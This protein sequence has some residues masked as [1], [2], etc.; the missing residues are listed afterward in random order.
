[1]EA[2]V[3]TD[4]DQNHSV[5][6]IMKPGSGISAGSTTPWRITLFEFALSIPVLL[7]IPIVAGGITAAFAC[8]LA[9]IPV[10]NLVL[11]WIIWG[12]ATPLIYTVWLLLCLVISALDVQSRRWYRGLKKVPR[13]SSSEGV[14]KFYP[15]I[16]LY[17]RMRFLYSLPMI[18]SLLW[19]P[20]I[21]WLVLWSYAPSAH[22]GF[23]SAILGKL[24][25]PD[26]TEVGERAIVGSGVS[27][28]AHSLTRNPDGTRLLT[29]APIMIGPRAVIG[30]DS[31]IS[32][33]VTIGA[34]AIIEPM[35]HV[36]AST[37]IPP[38]E[39]WGGVPAVFRRKRF[40]TGS[41]STGAGQIPRE[42]ASDLTQLVD[43]V[44]RVVAVALGLPF[45]S[46]STTFSANECAAWDSL[47]QM[48]I[49]SVL[50]SLR[51]VEIPTER[52]F[53]LQSVPEIVDYLSTISARPARLVETDLPPNPE[54]LPLLDHALATQLLAQRASRMPP[55]LSL[56]ATK[57]VVAATFTAH[58]LHST[59]ALWSN[60]FGIPVDLE[61]AG[62]NQIPQAL[63]SPEGSFRRNTE[64]VNVVLTRPEDLLAG[65]GWKQILS[66]IEQ[67]AAECPK[68]LF[69]ANLPPVVSRDCPA[70]R[71]EIRRLRGDWEQALSGIAGVDL[72]DF[73]NIVERIGTSAAANADGDRIAGIA[74]SAE[75]Y[76]ELG[77]TIARRVRRHRRPP[78]KV[79]ALDADGVLW[80]KV[81]GEDGFDG[82]SLGQEGVGC[83]FQ[84]FQ[85]TIQQLKNE[86]VL[87]TV[88]SRNEPDELQRVFESHPGMILRPE[89]IAAW[90]VNWQPKSENL[91]E[92][93]R[94]LNVGLDSFVLVDDDLAN[95]LEVQSAL[96]EVTVVPLPSDPSQFPSILQRLWCFD[97]A[98]ATNAD[99][100]RT[101]MV[102]EERG[103]RKL[104]NDSKDL[105]SYLSSLQLRVI[106]RIAE[107]AD[108]AR[109]AQLT[110]KT[111][112][113]NLSLRRR[114]EAELRNLSSDYSIFVVEV[115]DRLGDYGLVGLCILHGLSAPTERTG[116]DSLLI[117]CRAL[118]RRVEDAVLHGIVEL[119]H[120]SGKSRI[121]AEFVPGPRNQPIIDFLLRAGFVPSG[122]G[123]YAL[124]ASTPID[125]PRSILWV[126]PTAG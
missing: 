111:N 41:P 92:M 26:L 126:G 52:C 100:N 50:F 81:L 17:L 30:G 54:L 31:L 51:G 72:L 42:V 55:Q 89:D 90:R 73:A 2:R 105:D 35:S 93:A 117:S 12:C 43:E 77:I 59:L 121:E 23:G 36:K 112:Q 83:Q 95:Q 21:R 91:R 113:F 53:R 39:V 25:D 124:N 45:D 9:S 106:M 66:A 4:N 1:M 47:G 61:S 29:T 58:P 107:P 57:V 85:R 79:L 101:Q 96:P 122:Q 44:R 80:G 99:A 24:F 94:E 67:F 15:V 6:S 120:L 108:M 74:Y 48:T 37:R 86:G 88:V 115:S 125:L 103:R 114:S 118:G 33:G 16:S 32:L 76:A 82:I 109:V 84:C 22:L 46:V 70:S 28:V 11:R 87:L 98:S 14:T 38:G 60:A 64:G 102:V 75:V 65:D 71:E 34:D 104:R 97:A 19:I 40:E 69:V 13:V 10:S 20:G 49:A 62:F 78:A 56:P 119:V 63:L 123:R 8:P 5:E 27:V 68:A 18:G 116:I 7:T 110:Q 3:E